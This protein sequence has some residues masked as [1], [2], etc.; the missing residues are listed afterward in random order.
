MKASS[1]GDGIA[2]AASAGTNALDARLAM[3][4]VMS[5][6]GTYCDRG[7]DEKHA[8]F[9]IGAECWESGLEQDQLRHDIG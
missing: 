1:F 4:T 3:K 8:T 9:G 7:G 2:H 5:H 6:S